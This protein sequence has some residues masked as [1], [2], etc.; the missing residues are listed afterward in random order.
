MS[1]RN[2][3]WYSLNAGTD[4]P[5]DDT[6]TCRTNDGRRLPPGFLVDLVLRWPQTLGAY[7]FVGAVSITARAVSLTLEAAADLDGAR[8]APLA[9]LALPQPA[10]EGRQY[11]L[12]PQAAG[13][14]GWVVFGAALRE[15]YVWHGRFASP[16][17]SLLTAKAA[18]PYRPLPVRSVRGLQADQQLTGIIQLR[19]S[20]PLTI[21]AESRDIAGVER[22]AIVFRLLAQDSAGDFTVSALERQLVGS[23]SPENLFRDFA[24][25]CKGRPESNTCG[26]PAPIEFINSVG[27]TCAGLITLDF[28]GCAVVAQL[29]PTCGIVLDCGTGLSQVCT[30]PFI[31]DATGRLPDALD[32]L[33]LPPATTTTTTTTT[34]PP[35][36]VG[37]AGSLPYTAC[38][39]DATAPDFVV[40]EGTF[41]FVAD[42]SPQETDVCGLDVL[43]GDS[44]TS[45]NYAYVAESASTPNLALWQGFELLNLNRRTQTDLKL[46]PGP[47]GARHNG[48]LILNWRPHATLPERVV[49]YYL[50]ID[51]DDQELRIRWFNGTS[52][53]TAASVAVPGLVL[54]HWYRL[55]GDAVPGPSGGQTV[56]TAHLQGITNPALSATL[57][58][59]TV[60]NYVPSTGFNGLGSQRS[61][62]RFSYFDYREV[63]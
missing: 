45:P 40:Q 11:A 56:L 57:G 19:A 43:P 47:S 10:D 4:Y 51:Q 31:P 33:P 36:S 52:L 27:P 18:R 12:V 8:P 58:P 1:I 15:P 41:T 3:H 54:E 49:Y 60:T 23:P 17:Q 14:G 63:P 38:F 21:T 32:P 20:S 62:C 37:D 9:V 22:D 35:E 39:A 55:R 34:P 61:V 53:L 42:D 29:T 26:N 2:E 5:V 48:G 6:A 16:R 50:T 46:M 28:R 24:G 13:V 59:L 25:P 44:F 7:A 30:P